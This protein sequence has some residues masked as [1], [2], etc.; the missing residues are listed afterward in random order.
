MGDPKTSRKI[1]KKP[2]RPLNYDLIMDEL[3][4]LGTFG[5]KQRESYGKH[6]QSYQE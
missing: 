2:K 6:K 1:W 5:L 4:T 3:Q